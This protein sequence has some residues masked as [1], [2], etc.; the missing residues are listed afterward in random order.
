MTPETARTEAVVKRTMHLNVPIEFAFRILTQEMGTWWPATHH[1]GKTPFKE[2]VIEPRVGGR[3]F[4]RNTSGAECEWGKVLVW[5]PPKQ[6][7]V[8]WHLQPNWQADPDM[9]R[10]S[11]VSF[12]FFA[13]SPEVTRLE[14]EHRHLERHGEGWEKMRADV[15][16]PGGWTTVL[17]GFE[18]VLNVEGRRQ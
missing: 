10:A 7:V 17:A 6:V 5:E 18:Q 11:E 9:A 15:D 1:I 8:S 3:W 12:E 2:I 13:E 16:S 14:F 4:E